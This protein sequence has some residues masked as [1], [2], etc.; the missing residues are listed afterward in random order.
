NKDGGPEWI[1]K[2]YENWGYAALRFD[3]RGCGESGGERG[4]VIPLEEVA[5][6]RNAL[7]YMA[8]RPDGDPTRIPLCRSILGAGVAVY[9]AGIDP[10]IAAVILEIVLGNGERI[11]RSMHTPES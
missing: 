1:C 7:T 8:S 6:A 3:Y 2:Q 11:I 10:R 4:R 9:A 5:D